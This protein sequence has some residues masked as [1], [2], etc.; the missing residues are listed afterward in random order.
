MIV[1]VERVVSLVVFGL[2]RLKELAEGVGI[3]LEISEKVGSIKHLID[4][5]VIFLMVLFV[6]DIQ[7]IGVQLSQKPRALYNILSGDLLNVFEAK[8]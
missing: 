1:V 6:Q 4:K 7:I 5:L 2:E 8:V 3:N